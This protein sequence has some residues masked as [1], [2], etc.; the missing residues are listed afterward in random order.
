VIPAPPQHEPLR[1]QPPPRWIAALR[2][3][4]F[5]LFVG[6]LLFVGARLACPAL[7]PQAARWP[8]GLLL[9]LAT[10]TTL[11]A[12]AR[13]LPFQNVLLAASII[14]ALGTAVHL[15]GPL[16]A[17][18]ISPPP[19]T[20][21]LTHLR[22]PRLSCAV[23]AWW[24]VA[25]LSSR[26]VAG[27]ILERWRHRPNYGLCRI[28][29]TALLV[30][31]LNFALVPFAAVVKGY[32]AW[33]PPRLSLDWYGMPWIAPVGWVLTAL[34]ILTLATPALLNKLPIATPPDYH[35]LAVWLLLNLLFLTAG[36]AHRLWPATLAVLLQTSL[37]ACLALPGS[38]ANAPPPSPSAAPTP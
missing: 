25:I 38:R 7:T 11:A 10:A 35:S 20:D 31:L 3:G 8:E 6:Q 30:A 23:P 36:I 28:A 24:L 21:G 5:A 34:L 26:G 33:P 19:Q 29:L 2:R 17:L 15:L 37:V 27:L 18:P 14:A 22:L 9:A 13:H 16:A 32:W 12:L 1:V 4:L